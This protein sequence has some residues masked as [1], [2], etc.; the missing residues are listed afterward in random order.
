MTGAQEQNLKIEF[1]H[2]VPEPLVH[3]NLE[4]SQ[5]WAS[6][7]TLDSG[8]KV[9]ISAPSGSGKSTLIHIL[10]GLR[11]DFRGSLLLDSKPVQ[12]L[13]WRQW[14]RL[15]QEQFSV[16][17][18]DLRLFPDLTARENLLIKARLGRQPYMPS[19]EEMAGLLGIRGLLDQPVTSLSQGERQRVAILR[20]LL[21]PFRWLFLDEPF[22]HLDND[23]I[24]GA[25]R[26]IEK[27]CQVN[28]A[29]MLLCQ[30]HEDN[31][32]AYDKTLA[33]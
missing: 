22:S 25:V 14:T 4:D 11:R 28:Q 7:L 27:A 16:V 13:G 9:H 3:R 17:F 2:I 5:V 23:N 19:M 32:F 10:Y 29:G 6:A 20:A 18:Q 21:Q 15:R 8:Q 33:M 26:L 12:R 1:D 31:L 24:E 30:L